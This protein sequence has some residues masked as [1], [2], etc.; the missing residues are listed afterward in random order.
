MRYLFLNWMAT[1][2]PFNLD[3]VRFKIKMIMHEATWPEAALWTFLMLATLVTLVLREEESHLHKGCIEIDKICLFEVYW[4]ITRRWLV[5]W[6]SLFETILRQSL[7]DQL[8]SGRQVSMMKLSGSIKPTRSSNTREAW[9]TFLSL[10]TSKHI[11]V[12]HEN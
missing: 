2:F 9:P 7:F 8:W 11:S 5:H 10:P 12:F 4:R 3:D 1:L 6:W